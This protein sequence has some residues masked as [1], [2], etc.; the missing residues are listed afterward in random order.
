M[1]VAPKTEC[2]WK[3]TPV[4]PGETGAVINRYRSLPQFLLPVSMSNSSGGGAFWEVKLP[5][6]FWVPQCPSSPPQGN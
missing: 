4:L 1:V 2:P 3:M 6:T 5:R